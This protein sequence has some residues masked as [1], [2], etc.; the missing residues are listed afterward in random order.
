MTPR[1]RFS[2]THVGRPH[3]PRPLFGRPHFGG[4]HFDWLADLALLAALAVLVLAT[5][6]ICSFVPWS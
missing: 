5:A 3:A 6:V 1:I 2:R 4:G